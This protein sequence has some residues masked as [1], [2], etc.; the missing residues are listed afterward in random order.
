MALQRRLHSAVYT[1]WCRS[2]G[3]LPVPNAG[4]WLGST[5]AGCEVCR[6]SPAENE[7]PPWIAI[8]L[9]QPL[10]EKPSCE[11]GHMTASDFCAARCIFSCQAGANALAEFRCGVNTRINRHL[12]LVTAIFTRPEM[13]DFT[14]AHVRRPLRCDQQVVAF[15]ARH[16]IGRANVDSSGRHDHLPYFLVSYG[17]GR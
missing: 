6:G 11:A 13:T 10:T 2:L 16:S 8:Y 3:A 14:F 17:V 9:N 15:G 12:D 5:P 7:S 1:E 4:Q